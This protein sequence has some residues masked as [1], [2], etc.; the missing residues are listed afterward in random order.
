MKQR[1]Q[2]HG[3]DYE[4]IGF[5][6]LENDQEILWQCPKTIGQ[7]FLHAI[8]LK[9]DFQLLIRDFEPRDT[10][11]MTFEEDSLPL[12]FSFLL[13]GGIHNDLKQG[14]WNKQFFFT[15]GQT[16]LTSFPVICGRCVHPAGEH[17]RMINIWISENRLRSL[18]KGLVG[19]PKEI[20]TLLGKGTRDP[21]FFGTVTPA[22]RTALF[23]IINC[24]F[25]GAIRRLFLESKCMELICYQLAQIGAGQIQA[26]PCKPFSN[27]EID[28]IHHARDLLIADLQNPPSVD[29][30]SKMVGTNDYTGVSWLDLHGPVKALPGGRNSGNRL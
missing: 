4:K 27:N 8:V 15:S 5:Q 16:S 3:N 25:C 6:R 7:G 22:F 18:L 10:V 26:K 11:T 2:F 1:I 29:K 23:D 13:S 28:R 21:M 24:P 14:Q 30:L 19:D 17:M 20:E 12:V 9:P